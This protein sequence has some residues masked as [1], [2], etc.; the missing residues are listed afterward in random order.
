VAVFHVLAPDEMALPFTHDV[1]LEDLETGRRGRRARPCV[2]ASRR[3]RRVSRVAHDLRP[4][5]HDYHRVSTTMPLDAAL[6][7]YLRRRTRS[8][9]R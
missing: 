4:P 2:G 8:D 9:R 5:R 7:D 6:G 3:L 1:E